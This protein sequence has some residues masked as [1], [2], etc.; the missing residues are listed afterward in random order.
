MSVVLGLLLFAFGSL[1]PGF[2]LAYAL[3]RDSEP[4]VLVTAGTI[5]GV[6]GLPSLHFSLAL[7][8]GRSVSVGLV[9]AVAVLTIAGSIAWLR[10][11]PSP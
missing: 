6:F 11:R 5:A 10:L 4:V 7:L 3:L 8:L 2:V 9:L 1:L